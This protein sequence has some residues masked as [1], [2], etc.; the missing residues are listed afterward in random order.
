VR[1][2]GDILLL[3]TYELGHQP[4]ALAGPLGFFEHAGFRP[5]AL[6][7]AVERLDEEAVRRARLVGI[8]VPMHTALRLGMRAAARVRALHPGCHICFY[9][10]YAPLNR[11]VLVTDERTSVVG[12]EYETELVALAE[13]LERGEAPAPAEVVLERLPF[14]APMRDNLPHIERYARLRVDGEERPAGYT[15][16][17]RGCLHHCRHCPIPAVY[18]GRFFVVPVDVVL[19]DVRRQVAAGA[20]HVTL[21]DADFLNGPGHALAVARALHAEHP[22]LTFDVTTKVEHILK[23]RELFPELRALGC[24]FVVSAVESLSDRVL[25]LLDK[26]H[27]RADV[28][29][30]VDIVEGAGIALRPSLVSFTPWTTLEDY[31][32]VIDWIERRRLVD[33]V[34]PIHLAIRLLIPPGSKLLELPEVRA[35]VGPLAPSLLTYSWTHSDPRMDELQR[36]VLAVVEAD[37]RD[38]VDQYATFCRIRR[39][40]LEAAGPAARSADG[41]P[42][43]P[44]D[45]RDGRPVAAPPPDRARPP[46]L[47]EAWFC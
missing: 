34:E 14:V 18:G 1:N 2:P 11:E 37:A 21:G 41:R 40:A 16:A 26:G 28:D 24:L 12:G 44:V 46:R 27:T 6:D 13:R 36:A 15:E 32:E 25:T 47:T 5:R 7:L 29:R 30:A 10:L 17:S 35:I 23:H 42:G 38:G 8:A 22:R 45:W 43:R 39:L 3:S 33:H 20:R 31:L 4:L 9:G 19:A